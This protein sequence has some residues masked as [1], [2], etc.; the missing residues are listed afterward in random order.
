MF[1]SMN[2]VPPH[3]SFKKDK[4]SRD[5]RIPYLDECLLQIIFQCIECSVEDT[6]LLTV[7]SPRGHILQR[8]KVQSWQ[9]QLYRLTLLFPKSNF[10]FNPFS[11]TTKLY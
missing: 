8:V 4:H 7:H 6:E 11:L 5:Y 1:T 2:R 9:I 3:K 10:N